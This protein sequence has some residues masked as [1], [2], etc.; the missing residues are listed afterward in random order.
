MAADVSAV[1]HIAT[2]YGVTDSEKNELNS[3]LNMIGECAAAKGRKMPTHRHD[4][5]GSTATNR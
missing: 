4:G 1:V 3:F 5:A 2:L